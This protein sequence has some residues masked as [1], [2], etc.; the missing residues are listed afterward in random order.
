M[1]RVP[2]GRELTAI[3]D[4]EDYET[5]AAHRW[6]T[7]P[8]YQTI[9][10]REYEFCPCG[11][12][13]RRM[14][15]SMILGVVGVDH[16]DGNGLNNL[17]SNIRP[18]SSQQNAGNK[19]KPYLGR[20][21]NSKYK[22]VCQLNGRGPW[23]AQIGSRKNRRFLGSFA[24]EEQAARAYDRAARETFGPYARLNFPEPG[25]LSAL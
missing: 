6:H 25:E 7:H 21:P 13:E 1:Q 8:G 19:S 5:V 2:V 15:H 16:V 14:M 22:G 17:R 4:D 12:N 9:Y 20:K 3:V 11:S 23:R 10:A 18:A 24:T